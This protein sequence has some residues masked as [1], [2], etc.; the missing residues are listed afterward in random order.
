[1][2]GL[3]WSPIRGPEGN[4]EYLMYLRRNHED[5]DG[6]RNGELA[7]AKGQEEAMS[8]LDEL[9]E[10]IREIVRRSHETL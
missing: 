10:K 6:D 5:S 8:G 2:E 3:T 9:R 1:M 7:A 4:I